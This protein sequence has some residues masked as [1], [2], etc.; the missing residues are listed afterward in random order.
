MVTS[1]PVNRFPAGNRFAERI[2]GKPRQHRRW[3]LTSWFN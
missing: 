1:K 2:T 3:S